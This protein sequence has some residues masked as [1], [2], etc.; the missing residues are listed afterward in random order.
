MGYVRMS[1]IDVMKQ[2]VLMKG[3]I[4]A[5]DSE[6]FQVLLVKLIKQKLLIKCVHWRLLQIMIERF[7][8]TN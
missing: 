4:Q 5:Y 8:N 6:N 7:G 2:T 3:P 1:L